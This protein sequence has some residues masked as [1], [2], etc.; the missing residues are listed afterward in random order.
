MK[1]VLNSRLDNVAIIAGWL[2]MNGIQCQFVEPR[3]VQPGEKCVLLV[4][5]VYGIIK[6][7]IDADKLSELEN[8]GVRVGIMAL[9]VALQMLPSNRYGC[10]NVVGDFHYFGEEFPNSDLNQSSMR[11]LLVW[12]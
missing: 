7:E 10:G 8:K 1:F 2:R 12:C 9:H 3:D 6:N 5:H 4:N 11:E